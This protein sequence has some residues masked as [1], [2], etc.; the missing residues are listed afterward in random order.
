[1]KVTFDDDLIKLPELLELF[2]L[3]IDPSSLNRQGNDVGEQYRTGIYYEDASEAETVLESLNSLSKKV[4]K[5][6][7]IEESLIK[8]F[9]TAEEYHQKYL[10]KN[11]GGYCHIGKKYFDIAKSYKRVEKNKSQDLK[12]R[13]SPLQYEVTQNA[14]TEPPFKNEYFNNFEPGIY[15]DIVDGTPL[16]A[17]SD[18]F[19][20]G[21]GWPSF[22]KPIDQ[23]LL[24]ELDDN[25]YGRQRT[26]VRAKKSSSHLGH[27]FPDGPKDLGGLRYCINSASLKF[28]PLNEMEKAGYG[29][30]FLILNSQKKLEA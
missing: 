16:F 18:K 23:K 26:E 25:S 3:V 28:I 22:S 7:M 21:C 20:S 29:E 4:D 8:N 27:V 10:E 15:V 6:L 17:S 9:Y 12:E 5:P 19:E 13:L 30:L 11:P 14:G 24:Y 2:Y 1:V